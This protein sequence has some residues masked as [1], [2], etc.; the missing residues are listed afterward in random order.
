MKGLSDKSFLQGPTENLA[1]PSLQNAKRYW[2]D[3]G[4]ASLFGKVNTWCQ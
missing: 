2:D 4:C 1:Q 3:V